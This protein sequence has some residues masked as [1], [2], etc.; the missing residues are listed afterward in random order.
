MQL[1]RE[2]KPG[3]CEISPDRKGPESRVMKTTQS[4]THN[5]SGVTESSF[6][7]RKFQLGQRVMLALPIR[8]P[9]LTNSVPSTAGH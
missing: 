6:H 1:G 7:N 5:I 8:I 4:E 9:V 2:S 3:G